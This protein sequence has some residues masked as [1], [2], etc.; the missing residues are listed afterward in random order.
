MWL[1]DRVY[2]EQESLLRPLPYLSSSLAGMGALHVLDLVRDNFLEKC[3][4]DIGARLTGLLLGDASG[5]LL[6]GPR[7]TEM[8][9]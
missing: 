1:L 9:G 3:L 8:V 6:Q 7:Q 5:D 2:S 4:W